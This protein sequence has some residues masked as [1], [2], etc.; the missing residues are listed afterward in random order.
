MGEHRVSRINQKPSLT[1]PNEHPCYKCL[2]K[3]CCSK[4]CSDFFDW[5]GILQKAHGHLSPET[6]INFVVKHSRS[7]RW[8]TKD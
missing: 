2:T 1:D 7:N 6:M 3:A 5:I 4:W 8:T